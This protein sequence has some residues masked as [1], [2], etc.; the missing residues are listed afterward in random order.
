M[1]KLRVSALPLLL[2][3]LAPAQAAF[4]GNEKSQRLVSEGNTLSM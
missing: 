1:T 2:A 3:V 4:H